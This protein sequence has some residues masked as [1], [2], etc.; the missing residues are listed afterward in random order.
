M[1]S[2]ISV[3]PKNFLGRLR[4]IVPTISSKKEMSHY[5][6]QQESCQIESLSYLFELFFGL[7]ESG[8][9]VEVGANDGKTCS[10]TWGLAVRNWRG[11]Y[12]EPINEYAEKCR[13]NHRL[14]TKVSVHEVAIDDEDEKEVFFSI[15]GLLTTAN[16]KVA[17]RYETLDW[18]RTSLTAEKR[19]V[20]TKRL[21]TFLTEQGIGAAFELLVIDVEGLEKAV[22][23]GFDIDKWR[24]KMI[25]IELT[26]THP[27][28]AQSSFGDRLISLE[29]QKSGY[30]I[31]Y[32]DS[33]NTVYLLESIYM[34]ESSNLKDQD[35]N[36]R[37]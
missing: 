31:V 14:N 27:D 2:R 9:F 10:N 4:S 22:L 34:T 18:A 29:I 36:P 28:L 15:A 13:D 5:Y 30:C 3:L 37:T 17:S 24:P 23:E 19:A 6:E 25:I 11:Y 1:N 20:R 35:A 16:S 7:N 8:T 33:I 26:D 12:I 32:K 21:D